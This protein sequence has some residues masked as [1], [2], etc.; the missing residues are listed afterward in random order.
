[1][2]DA[3]CYRNSTRTGIDR[4]YCEQHVVEMQRCLKVLAVTV[5]PL[6]LLFRLGW[7]EIAF[8][9]FDLADSVAAMLN[10][11][12]LRLWLMPTQLESSCFRQGKPGTGT[13]AAHWQTRS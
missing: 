3:V 1:M 13:R 7:Q 6:I 11:A 10:V 2:V 12:E 5:M 4:G 9:N 8:A